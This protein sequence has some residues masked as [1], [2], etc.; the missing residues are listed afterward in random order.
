MILIREQ[1]RLHK[2]QLQRLLVAVVDNPVLS[3]TL[4]FKGGTAA[5]M[6]GFLDRFSV[7]LDFD[8]KEGSDVSKVRKEFNKIFQNLDYKVEKGG[9]KSLFFTLKYQA[10][11][12][13]RNTIKISAFDGAVKNNDYGLV[14]I[15]EIDRLVTCQ[16]IE[17]MFANKLVTV[18][19]RYNRHKEV[20]GRDIYDIHYFSSQGYGFKEEIIK[21]RTGLQSK[22]YIKKLIDFIEEKVTDKII[23]EDLNTLLPLPKFN[24]IRKVL[25]QETLMFLRGLI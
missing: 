19:D 9:D 4:Y 21:E 3:Q 6:L 25:K 10:K 2:I 16:T 11:D 8:L 18:I 1:D 14:K 13:L 23:T 24:K 7:D 17:T 5:T 22:E 20:A 12:G 15:G